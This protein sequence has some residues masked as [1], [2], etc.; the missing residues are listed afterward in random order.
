MS[1]LSLRNQASDPPS[2][3]KRTTKHFL[4]SLIAFVIGCVLWWLWVYFDGFLAAQSWP[5]FV[6]ALSKHSPQQALYFWQIAMYFAPTFSAVCVVSY[7][8]F[9][10]IGASKPVLFA[11]VLPYALLNWA[12][13]S[14]EP[15]SH[16]W[17]VSSYTLLSL[18]A[19]SAF[20]LGLFLAWLLARRIPRS[21]P[22]SGRPPA[23]FAV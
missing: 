22:S 7:P 16:L 10:F 17:G 6:I 11:A 1:F 2:S 15:L 5:K 14:L 9:R 13:G 3:A 18:I 19:L 4:C 21:P 12:G 20:P 23:G 8:L